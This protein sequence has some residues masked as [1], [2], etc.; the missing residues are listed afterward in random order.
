MCIMVCFLYLV[1]SVV[2]IVLH[3]FKLMS[4]DIVFEI[5]LEGMLM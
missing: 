1:P 2:F 3:I 4:P 5:L